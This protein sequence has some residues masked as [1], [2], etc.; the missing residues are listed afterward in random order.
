MTASMRRHHDPR[1][2]RPA[3]R[4]ILLAALIA[5]LAGC[6]GSGGGAGRGGAEQ[7]FVAGNGSV[8]T[9]PAADRKPA[10]ALIGTTLTGDQFDLGALRGKVVVLNVWASWCAPCRA[11]APHLEQTYQATKN[12]GVAFVGLNTR[13][14]PDNARAFERKVGVS[15]PSVVDRDGELVVAFRGT[16]PPAAIP[17]TLV[18][19]RE[20]RMAARALTPLTEPMLRDLIS[21]IIAEPGRP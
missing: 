17:T 10:P 1:R 5:A 20:G 11:E 8:Q 13:D 12:D 14:E 19:D 6:S 7:A 16:L 4:A 2:S 18:I 9:V 15:Y 21:P 3:G